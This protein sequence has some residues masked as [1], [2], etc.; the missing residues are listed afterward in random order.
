MV[1]VPPSPA[2]MPTACAPTLLGTPPNPSHSYYVHMQTPE[3]LSISPPD[4][5][6][7]LSFTCQEETAAGAGQCSM[8]LTGLSDSAASPKALVSSMAAQ[9]QSTSELPP[10]AESDLVSEVW[11]E[12][13]PMSLTCMEGSVSEP[14]P[15]P[16]TPTTDGGSVVQTAAS[17]PVQLEQSALQ[18]TGDSRM[19]LTC[20]TDTPQQLS[21]AMAELTQHSNSVTSALP[22]PLGTKVVE[23][24]DN[25]V[26]KK[27]KRLSRSRRKSHSSGRRVVKPSPV[28]RT[29]R[30]ASQQMFQG[31]SLSH[32][33]L[34]PSLTH[35]PRGVHN[36]TY[37]VT[38][39]AP[40][41]TQGL[42]GLTE[43][44]ASQASTGTGAPPSSPT[45]TS[46]LLGVASP[47]ADHLAVMSS[48][49]VAVA[50]SPAP[51]C[52]VPPVERAPL[53][54][55]WLQTSHDSF[56]LVTAN[57]SLATDP[58]CPAAE[59]ALA[60]P[61]CSSGPCETPAAL[62][63]LSLIQPPPSLTPVSSSSSVPPCPPLS[64]PKQHKKPCQ[65]DRLKMA[66]ERLK[67]RGP[68]TLPIPVDTPESVMVEVPPAPDQ[69]LHLSVLNLTLN[70]TTAVG[71]PSMLLS[72]SVY[73]KFTA[74]LCG[75]EGHPQPV[76]AE[77]PRAGPVAE[78]L[79]ESPQMS[80][81][82]Q[83]LP[84]H[85]LQPQPQSL[86]PAEPSAHPVPAGGVT[87]DTATSE[88][89]FSDFL[90]DLCSR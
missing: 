49:A 43:N 55:E 18:V 57:D 26:F 47:P 59:Q 36:T 88:T 80:R 25:S 46:P 71:C 51:T 44:A 35:T 21:T 14:S 16:A 42:T 30:T 37:T 28:V 76:A 48:E 60:P 73:D 65:P 34:T 39:L 87:C 40:T 85:S 6:Q 23:S 38:P 78:S 11:A 82:D 62:P 72:P 5:D 75:G 31:P 54:S 27:P 79:P 15:V 33:S 13:A 7:G 22:D 77:A 70:D 61:N 8:D 12:T 4:T 29:P 3:N 41:V 74:K 69:S 56:N 9:P 84:G 19:S 20:V 32:P 67:S 10:P 86:A 68:E 63:S 52:S 1:G 89:L 64:V 2:H 45:L 83:P 17:L 90:A 81:E 66:V 53:D 50:Q 58:T 24:V